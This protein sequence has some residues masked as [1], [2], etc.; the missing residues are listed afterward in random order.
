MNKDMYQ[1]AIEYELLTKAMY[2]DML[3]AEGVS[4]VDVKH[5][6]LVKGRSGVA[7]QVDVSWQ[8]SQAAVTHTVLVECKN[9]ASAITLDKVRNFFAVLHDIG[10]CRG[11]MVTK[12]GYQAGVVD[13]AKHYGIGLK[14]LRKP[15]EEDWK[16]KIKTIHVQIIPRGIVSTAE[17]PLQVFI[18]LAGKTLDQQKRLEAAQ[19]SL[20]G[21]LSD[22]ASIRLLD[23]TGI[24]CTEEFRW[25]LPKLINTLKKEVGG[26]YEESLPIGEHYLPLDLGSG[27]ELVKVKSVKVKYFVEEYDTREIIID[28]TQIVDAILKD[29]PT[30]TVEHVK[31]NE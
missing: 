13:F 16:D 11:L 26:P 21:Q 17:K 15:T 6:T 9:Y 12:T 1:A 29:F 2:E 5:D 8:F 28:G 4:T 20:M 31:R 19:P 25:W 14:L 22:T 24:P 10:N 23:A 18:H 30:N 27:Q 7:H 3:H